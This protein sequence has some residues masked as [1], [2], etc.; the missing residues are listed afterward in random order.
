MHDV[1]LMLADNDAES[2][3]FSKVIIDCH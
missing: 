2:N 1:V 3:S